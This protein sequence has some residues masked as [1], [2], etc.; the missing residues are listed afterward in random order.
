[1][2]ETLEPAIPDHLD[3]QTIWRLPAVNGQPFIAKRI[4]EREDT[5]SS[6]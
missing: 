4:S 3:G 2:S 6:G 1:M 5:E